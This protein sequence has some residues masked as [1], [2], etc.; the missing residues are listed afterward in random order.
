M[1]YILTKD[2]IVAD[3]GA[4][5][6][7][8]GENYESD[9]GISLPK[10]VVESKPNFFKKIIQ[11]EVPQE[12]DLFYFVDLGNNIVRLCDGRNYIFG[13]LKALVETKNYF[14]SEEDATAKLEAIRTLLTS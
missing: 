10:E 11:N 1:K 7:L 12:G 5:F 4:I 8:V 14:G 6:S 13:S 2:I 3:E 9:N